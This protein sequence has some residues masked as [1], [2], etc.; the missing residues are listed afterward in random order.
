MAFIGIS[1]LNQAISRIFT[2]NY[3]ANDLTN[4][5]DFLVANMVPAGSVLFI[6]ASVTLPDGWLYAEGG[7]FDADTYPD[8]YT[9][10]GNSNALPDLRNRIPIGAGSIASIGE[11]AGAS[12]VTLEAVNLPVHSHTLENHTHSV[13]AISLPFSSAAGV[14]D[15]F[16]Q[17]GTANAETYDIAEG[18]TGES[19]AGETGEAGSGEAFSIIPPVHGLRPIIKA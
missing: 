7:T 3:D 2:R 8:L 18:E 6:A 11:T 9:A 4:L 13:P 5:R 17:G 12:E 10:L 14:E 16:Y 15:T 1:S 19:G